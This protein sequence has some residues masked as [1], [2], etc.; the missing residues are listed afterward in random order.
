MRTLILAAVAA[1]A[2]ASP[3]LAQDTTPPQDN[4]AQATTDATAEKPAFD[5]FRVGA[6]V[7]Y[8]M[9]RP[10]S[11]QDSAISSRNGANGLLYGGDIGYDKTIGGRFVIGAE[12]ELTGSEARTYNDPYNGLGYGRVRQGRDFYAGARLGALLTPTTLLYAKGGYTNNRLDLV[13]NNGTIDTGRHF[14]L[15]GYRVGAGI[16]QAMSRHTYVKVEYRYS[17]YG[18]AR[19]EYPN[20]SNTNNF[21]VDTDRHQVALG[22]GVRF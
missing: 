10:G 5:G 18:S 20:G 17:N 15:D 2:I 22:F 6:I 19:L 3:A 8:D 11:T 12:G 1:T 13:A 4:A 9:L 7:G 21:G 16:E 14:N